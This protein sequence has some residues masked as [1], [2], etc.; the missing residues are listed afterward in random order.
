MLFLLYALVIRHLNKSCPQSSSPYHRTSSRICPNHCLPVEILKINTFS[1]YCTT[2]PN[3]AYMSAGPA[4]GAEYRSGL[5]NEKG[6]NTVDTERV[7]QCGAVSPGRE[8]TGQYQNSPPIVHTLC[9]VNSSW[10]ALTR[11]RPGQPRAKLY[12][13]AGKIMAIGETRSCHTIAQWYS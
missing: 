10:W 2:L 1:A 3:I 8:M 5:D 13:V 11:D 9:R 12:T 7:E 4:P 6:C